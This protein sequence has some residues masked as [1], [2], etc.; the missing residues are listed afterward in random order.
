MIVE[1]LNIAHLD[2]AFT[3]NGLVLTRV[4][5]RV[6]QFLLDDA[7]NHD[8]VAPEVFGIFPIAV[9]GTLFFRKV[10]TTRGERFLYGVIQ[11]LTNH[12]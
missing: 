5:V 10:D 4:L 2:L 12:P 1:N 8:G 7:E 6:R 3:A 11:I 9:F